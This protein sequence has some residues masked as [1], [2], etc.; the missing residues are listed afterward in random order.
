MSMDKA[1]LLQ[2][3]EAMVTAREIDALEQEVT[4]R[5]EAFFHVSGA[6]HE[7]SVAL[8]PH[9]IP[10]DWLHCHYRDKALM[11]ARGLTARDFFDSL[12]CNDHSHSR[13]R[14]MSAHM[15]DRALNLMSIVGPVG[16][17]ALQSVGVAAAIK[18][19]PQDPIVICS[20]GDGTTQEGEFLEA[21]AEAVRSELPV[22]FFVEDNRWAISTDTQQK[23]FYSLPQGSPEQFYGLPIHRFDGRNLITAEPAI[24]PVV[25]AV[26][27]SRGPALVV[28]EVER[29]TN[30]TNADDQTIYRDPDDIEPLTQLW[31]SH[32]DTRR[33]AAK[34]TD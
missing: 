15:S 6:G 34:T 3:F 22:L 29:L 26:R 31:R 23:T 9:L 4:S 16:N 25:R 28:F 32:S 7:A 21:V 33:V 17:S 2:L 1:Q 14:Q 12:Y 30:H 27:E 8:A 5:G 18:D 20:V 13:G 11:I 24:G 10:E 19:S